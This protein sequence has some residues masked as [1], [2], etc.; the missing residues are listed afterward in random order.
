MVTRTFARPPTCSAT[1]SSWVG[2]WH[3]TRTSDRSATSAFE[4]TA[5]P[6]VARAS[7][8]ALSETTSETT[9]GTLSPR[10]SA[11]A[12]FPAPI[13]PTLI[14]AE[15]YGRAAL[16]LV[17]KALL[18]QTGPLFRRDLDVP[19]REEEDLVG[20]PLHAAVERVREAGREVDEPLREIRVAALEVEDDGDR[21]LEL[22]GD[23]LGVIEALGHHQVH[24]E[25]A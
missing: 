11:E 15:A 3:S 7:A 23:L 25:L 22:I 12:M 21:V 4:P 17:E 14:G 1:S 13:S 18:D 2:L 5:S 8:S 10:A 24:L 6:P 20:D 9:T 16:G 19:G